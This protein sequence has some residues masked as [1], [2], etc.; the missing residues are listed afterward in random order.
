MAGRCLQ[1]HLEEDAL[2]YVIAWL[3]E[4]QNAK[5]ELLACPSPT[6]E[7]DLETHTNSLNALDHFLKCARFLRSGLQNRNAADLYEAADCLDSGEE[8]WDRLL[9]R[10]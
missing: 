2:A 5:K 1:L 7:E 4:L 9:K 3:E 8:V 10:R 6:G